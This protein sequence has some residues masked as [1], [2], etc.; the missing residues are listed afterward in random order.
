MATQQETE[1]RDVATT[2]ATTQSTNPWGPVGDVLR[3]HAGTATARAIGI[4]DYTV[5]NRAVGS[6]GMQHP[7]GV[8]GFVVKPGAEGKQA[9]DL[10]DVVTRVTEAIQHE[11]FISTAVIIPYTTGYFPSH[12]L[13]CDAPEGHTLAGVYP[14]AEHVLDLQ[15][16]LAQADVV[17]RGPWSI[18]VAAMEH[19]EDGSI[20]ARVDDP[21]GD[22]RKVFVGDGLLLVEAGPTSTAFGVGRLH[23]IEPGEDGDY[24]LVLDRYG[25][26]D[27]ADAGD[28]AGVGADAAADGAQDDD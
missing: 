11:P 10:N 14:A 19:G 23:H 18:V 27:D 4:Q 25:A 7:K 2:A 15:K 21:E 1:L 6:P 20:R 17:Q 8:H 9:A 13:S 12:V 28:G 22:L 3:E 16:G 26:L 24:I 5:I